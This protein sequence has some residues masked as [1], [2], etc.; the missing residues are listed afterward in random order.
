L[1]LDDVIVVQIEHYP[2]FFIVKPREWIVELGQC[3]PMEVFVIATLREVSWDS[4]R[5]RWGESLEACFFEW[6]VTNNFI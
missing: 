3:G 6:V 5:L 1:V 2:T 4:K